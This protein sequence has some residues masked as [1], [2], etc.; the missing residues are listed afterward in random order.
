[1]VNGD[2]ALRTVQPVMTGGNAS[3]LVRL[4]L[5]TA[6]VMQWLPWQPHYIT[7]FSA[8][9]TGNQTFNVRISTA[10]LLWK[11]SQITKIVARQGTISAIITAIAGENN[12]N[13]VVEPTVGNYSLI[14]HRISDFEFIITRCLA[15]ASNASGRG[16]FR[17]FMKD[18]VLHFHTPD[19]QS[20]LKSFNYFG[21]N[22]LDLVQSD[23]SQ[24][25]CED[26]IA[27]GAAVRMVSQDPVSGVTAVATSDNTLVLNTGNLA[28]IISSVYNR[29]FSCHVGVNGPLEGTTIIQNM[30]EKQQAGL[31]ELRLATAKTPSLRLNDFLNIT[32]GTGAGG[33]WSGYYNTTKLT[34]QINKGDL[35]S[36]FTLQRGELQ[37]AVLTQNAVQDPN[38][39]LPPSGAP[40]QPI[41][42][43][44]VN[45]SSTTTGAKV[46]GA[47]VVQ[48]PTI[49]FYP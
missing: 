13:S 10:D 25:T 9:P 45:S 2:S 18:G 41:N 19:Y 37:T 31:Y 30:Y 43:S 23:R 42:L 27:A 40:G 5:G 4:G 8:V 11:I 46:P 36:S 14:Q 49:P 22:S 35:T 12:V 3:C 6:S 32:L 48:D 26:G 16:N 47:T 28:P 24:E 39:V 21:A 7:E 33:S 17:I 34:H 20:S 15:R 44:E 1:M 29:E 38:V